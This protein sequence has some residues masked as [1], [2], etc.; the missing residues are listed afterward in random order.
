MGRTNDPCRKATAERPGAPGPRPSRTGRGPGSAD[1]FYRM[2]VQMTFRKLTRRESLALMAAAS[3]AAALGVF[4]EKEGS[5]TKPGTAGWYNSAAFHRYAEAEGLYRD[6]F[7]L[8]TP[9]A[10]LPAVAGQAASE[11]VPA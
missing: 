6:V 4:S 5:D 10:P 2:G 3:G 9:A 8:H 1:Q 7:S 11:A